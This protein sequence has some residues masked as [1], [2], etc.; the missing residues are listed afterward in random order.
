MERVGG[1]GRRGGK[2]GNLEEAQCEH[3][4]IHILVKTVLYRG[5]KQGPFKF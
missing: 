2:E 5:K 3:G 4:S 1:G